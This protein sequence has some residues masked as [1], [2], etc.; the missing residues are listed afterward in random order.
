M[1]LSQRGIQTNGKP[2]SNLEL[3]FEFWAD[4]FFLFKE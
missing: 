2:F 4:F 3:V 1:N